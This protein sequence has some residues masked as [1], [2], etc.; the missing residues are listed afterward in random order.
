MLFDDYGFRPYRHAERAAVD[1]FFANV[2]EQPIVL[3]TGQ[4]LVLKL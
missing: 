1:E 2:P 3:P 4:A